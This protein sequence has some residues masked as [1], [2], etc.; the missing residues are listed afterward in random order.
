MRSKERVKVKIPAGVDNGS[1][2]RL[3]SKGEGGLNGGTHGDLYIH[4]NVEA[5][6]EFIRSGSDIHSEVHIHVLQA[7]L[8]DEIEV[9]T[10]HGK[11]K[12]K[13]AAGTVDGKVLRIRGQGVTKLGSSAQGDHLVKIRIDVPTK[14]SKKEKELYKQLADEAGL[15]VKK[16]GGLFG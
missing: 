4:L 12:I 6:K 15:D 10:V 7:V 9:K 2:V 3:S 16:G 8:G 13:M 14:L 5:D 11:E 1:T